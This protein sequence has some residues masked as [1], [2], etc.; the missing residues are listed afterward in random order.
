MEKQEDKIITSKSLTEELNRERE[1]EGKPKITPVN[2][3]RGS[4]NTVAMR[5]KS[6]S[7]VPDFL[8]KLTQKK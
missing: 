3:M 2:S 1:R 7:S 5:D 8:V 4:T 6:W